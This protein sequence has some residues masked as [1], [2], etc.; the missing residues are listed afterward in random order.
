PFRPLAP[1]S[2][3]P[4]WTTTL[5]D[6]LGRQISRTTPDG[7][8]N[9]T[10]YSGNRILAEDQQHRIRIN[11][12]DSLDRL[13]ELWEVTAADSATESVTF[14]GYPGVAAGYVTRY[15]YNAVNNL[16]SVSQR[17]GTSG[18]NQLRSYTYDSLKR[19]TALSTPESGTL[20]YQYDSDS[21]LTQQ[22]DA[23]GIVSTYVRD[24]LRRITSVDYSNTATNPDV[25]RVYDGATNGKGRLWK[26][27]AGGS[28]SVGNNVEKTLV[29]SYDPVGR[30]LI[31]KQF[32][33]IN[34][35][36]SNPYRTSRTY[37]VAGRVTLQT[38][39]SDRTV[40]YNYD[41]AGRLADK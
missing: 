31:L 28:E 5:F 18:T 29:E 41:N 10:A 13:R 27:Y 7:A 17:F 32:F 20:N 4:I 38:Y 36:W 22:T 34:N 12:A 2:E 23:R 37:N 1:Q 15:G 16:T 26:S 8:V 40:T 21:N 19:L 9:T 24:E 39:P 25:T 3:T 30:P 6:A 35:V 14:P 11:V 33:K